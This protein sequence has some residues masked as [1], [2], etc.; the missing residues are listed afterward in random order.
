MRVWWILLGAGLG[1]TVGAQLAARAGAAVRSGPARP[2]VAL[3]FDD[4]PHPEYTLRIVEVLAHHQ[5]RATFFFV[6]RH[7]LELPEVARE[8]VR[9]GHCVGTHTLSHPHLWTLGPGATWREVAAGVQAVQQATG[10]RPRYFRPPWGTFNL[11]A[12]HACR[13]LGLVPVLW[14]VRGE[15]YRW[16]PSADEMVREVVRRAH[17][18]AVVNLHDRGGFPDTPARVL[19]ALPGILRGLRSRGLQPVSLDEL[20]GASD[21]SPPACSPVQLQ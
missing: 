8:V 5:V 16:K 20:L 2:Q 3:T 19:A 11:A 13:V 12:L 21:G 17:P 4:G 7:A 1:Y 14:T 10:I 15:G 9:A 6:G 18:G